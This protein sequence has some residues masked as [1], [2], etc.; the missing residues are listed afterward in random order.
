[1]KHS[2]LVTLSSYFVIVAYLPNNIINFFQDNIQLPNVSCSSSVRR[3]KQ[4]WSTNQGAGCSSFIVSALAN[5]IA[6]LTLDSQQANSMVS[7]LCWN[8]G[9]YTCITELRSTYFFRCRT[10]IRRTWCLTVHCSCASTW[11]WEWSVAIECG[12]QSQTKAVM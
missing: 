1:M 6:K 10:E 4:G 8:A 12:A 5:A 3:M 2:H 9:K 7:T 11:D